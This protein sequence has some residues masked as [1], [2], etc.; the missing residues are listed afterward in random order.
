MVAV[1]LLFLLSCCSAYAND[2]SFEA[3]GS[4][5]LPLRDSTIRMVREDL[6]I[7]IRGKEARIDVEYVFVNDGPTKTIT[8]G[9]VTPPAFGDVSENLQSKPQI[10]NFTVVVNGKKLV[11]KIRKVTPA[12]R[13]QNLH[14][15][16]EDFVYLFDATFPRGRTRV[17]HSYR[18]NA[19]SSVD[20][21][22]HVPYRLTTGTHWQG[23]SI[24][25]FRLTVDG[26]K[27]RL[28]GVPATFIGDTVTQLP[29]KPTGRAVRA[30]SVG[31]DHYYD[32]GPRQPDVVWSVEN[33]VLVLEQF[34]FAPRQ[35]LMVTLHSGL[36]LY[37]RAIMSADH[38]WIARLSCVELK[39]L[40]SWLEMTLSFASGSDD[41]DYDID[42]KVLAIVKQA[43]V[44]NQCR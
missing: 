7:T 5:L 19:G 13:S 36:S 44:K 32:D 14:L 29:W 20:A 39:E 24:D 18:F 3:S 42:R 11:W 35:D 15:Y 38:A 33:G 25:T 43:K 31:Y 28:I 41:R 23:G 26:G 17:K 16:A 21:P 4:T 40:R 37:E 6:K 9:F 30:D 1:V 12:E 27:G 34:N 2:S 22:I 8:V 10:K